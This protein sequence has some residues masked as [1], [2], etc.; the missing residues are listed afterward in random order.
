[1]S[2]AIGPSSKTHWVA[3]AIGINARAEEN[4]TAVGPS[5]TANAL[6][7]SAFGNHAVAWDL[8]TAAFGAYSRAVNVDTTTLGAFSEARADNSVAI[9]MGSYADRANTVSVGSNT[10]FESYDG[11]IHGPQL[12][13]I[14]NVAAGTEANDVVIKAQLDAAL[15]AALD[16]ALGAVGDGIVDVQGKL[17]G[18]GNRVRALEE[19][20]GQLPEPPPAAPAPPLGTGEGLAIGNN[21]SAVANSVALGDGAIATE[22]NTVAV[23]AAGAERRVV[24]VADAVADTDGVNLRQMQAAQASTL[25]QARTYTD[26][27]VQ[28]LNDQFVDLNT[29]V[30]E[31]LG[32]QDTRIDRMGAMSS[33]MMSM[34]INAAQGRS[35]RGRLAMGAGWQNGENALSLGYARQIGDRMSVSL[36]GA[37][38]SDERSAGVGFGIDL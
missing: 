3:V 28:A 37:F 4:G 6:K 38:S 24:H 5:A 17:E 15:D 19:A 29:R 35:D 2:V 31:R 30:D 22:A 33:A 26:Q 34:S 20:F 32:H 9:G 7:A 18:F 25:N 23:G 1:M 8:G 10:T 27:R 16:T 14:V 11:S 13:Q 21:S 36:G 12:R